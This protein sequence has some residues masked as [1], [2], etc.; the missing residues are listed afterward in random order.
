M[1]ER[2]VYKANSMAAM[3]AFAMTDKKI[4]NTAKSFLI[5]F[6]AALFLSCDRNTDNQNR[7]LLQNA[8]IAL[9]Q[10]AAEMT[11]ENL[12][13][14]LQN[15][16]SNSANTQGAAQAETLNAFTG[17]APELQRVMP[18]SWRRLNRM[19]VEEQQNFVEQNP[20]LFEQIEQA[21]PV[22]P[23]FGSIYIYS[24][25]YGI[26]TEQIGETTFYRIIYTR[27]DSPDFFDRDIVFSQ[28]LATLILGEM[29]LL[30]M[31][32]YN[33]GTLTQHDTRHLITSID[34]IHERDSIK[35][36]LLTRFFIS[37]SAVVSPFGRRYVNGQVA[38]ISHRA[39]FYFF[40]SFFEEVIA[41]VSD[42]AG[43]YVPRL[44]SVLLSASDALVDLD[45]P[46]RYSLQNA[47]DGDP[48]SGFVANTED[49]LMEVQVMF[50]PSRIKK[51]AIIN[52]YADLSMQNNRI[53]E[54]TVDFNLFNAETR[55]AE[56]IR[57][58][59]MVFA[60]NIPDYQILP[61][62]DSPPNISFLWLSVR[63]VFWGTAH[64]NTS[65]AE[66]DIKTESGWLF[67]GINGQ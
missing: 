48:S 40:E 26:Y 38:G 42:A 58:G 62:A 33:R 3:F 10:T 16:V 25:L 31:A 67:G 55:R 47:F 5:I 53:R 14:A 21:L 59:Q 17:G 13:A 39:D 57:L 51:I 29:R 11:E 8:D 45:I 6:S 28:A 54:L 50:A 2:A 7:A 35:G 20:L 60:D 30:M 9:E 32:M 27:D 49:G 37:D 34:I 22:L 46:L 36:I 15:T 41:L 18:N 12:N 66:L 1:V 19:S 44:P 63:D 43:A 56:R 4:A 24:F 64:N 52:G 65:L 61:V 23:Q